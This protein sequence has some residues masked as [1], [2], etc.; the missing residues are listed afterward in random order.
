[1]NVFSGLNVF[2]D[3]S[4][5]CI[6]VANIRVRVEKEGD[7]Y[8]AGCIVE[9]DAWGGQSIIV[10]IAFNQNTGPAKAQNALNLDVNPTEH[11]WDEIQRR[12]NALTDDKTLDWSKLK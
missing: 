8:T 2:S 9:R 1:M 12:L 4:L 11:L 6:A 7:C 3:K 5:Y 10:W